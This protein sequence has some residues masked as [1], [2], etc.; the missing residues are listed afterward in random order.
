[1]KRS[2]T[3]FLTNC[4]FFNQQTWKPVKD[5]LTNDTILDL[6]EGIRNLTLEANFT[7]TSDA[8]TIKNFLDNIHSA[9]FTPSG[10]TTLESDL[11]KALKSIDLQFKCN[12]NKLHAIAT[13][14]NDCKSGR[15]T[16]KVLHGEAD[17]TYYLNSPECLDKITPYTSV[18][19]L[20]TIISSVAKEKGW[21]DN[22]PLNDEDL[23][24]R[25]CSE[26]E[27]GYI[28][29]ADIVA[30]VNKTI[31]TEAMIPSFLTR[32]LPAEI[33]P[34]R[35]EDTC[36]LYCLY[37][38]TEIIV[39]HTGLLESQVKEII[40]SC[41]ICTVTASDKTEICH[42]YFCKGFSAANVEQT[43]KL[44]LPTVNDVINNCVQKCAMKESE[45]QEVCEQLKC[46]QSSSDTVASVLNLPVSSID[47]LKSQCDSIVQQC[48]VSDQDRGY[49]LALHCYV[50]FSATQI[51][52]RLSNLQL[53]DIE[54][55]I[56]S[57]VSFTLVLTLIS[58]TRGGKNKQ[59]RL[60]KDFISAGNFNTDY[61]LAHL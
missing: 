34:K 17:S 21:Y 16:L 30:Q 44:P 8:D 1:M 55:V 23:L 60:R 51:Q 28:K 2:S 48:A 35:K 40:P 20:Q 29:P 24:Y 39:K 61:V 52:Q 9:T 5:I 31:L 59:A 50:N 54:N 26:K 43:M 57:E 37:Q 38:P 27:K 53:E 22:C 41:G 19:E 4:C 45:K 13:V 58:T 12:A 6:L 3:I 46:K 42:S 33:T 14:I 18:E 49:I 7:D 15:D 36:K 11:T 10:I 25:V 56:K 32:C 47:E